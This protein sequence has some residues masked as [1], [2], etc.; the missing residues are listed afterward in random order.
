MTNQYS[1]SLSHFR[2]AQLDFDLVLGVIQNAQGETQRLSPI[3]LALLAYLVNHQGVVVS[4][5][6]LFEAVWPRQV[7]SDDVLTRAVSDIRAQ[8]AKLG[9]SSKFIETIP[10]RGY[11]WAI[12]ASLEIQVDDLAITSSATSSAATPVLKTFWKPAFIYLLIASLMAMLIMMSLSLTMREPTMKLAV[13]PVQV[14][15]PSI[16]LKG[17]ALDGALLNL[18]RKNPKIQLLSQAAVASRPQNPFPYFSNE[19][20]AVWVLESRISDLDGPDRI[21]LSLVDARTG[22]ELKSYAFEA[23]T[24]SEMG[25]KLAKALEQNLF[26]DN[27]GY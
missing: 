7:V 17:K 23:S 27:V 12:H 1:S 10:K 8:L 26:G 25:S 2:C 11:R 18:M 16:E 15:R 4:R 6:A 24:N 9:E 14:N 5:A 3:N 20:G 19:F 13:L 22:I 21:E